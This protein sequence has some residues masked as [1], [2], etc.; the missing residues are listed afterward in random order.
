[1][2]PHEPDG[3][4]WQPPPLSP[5]VAIGYAWAEGEAAMRMVL[6]ILAGIVVA[7]GCV[8]GVEALGHSLYPPPPGLDPTNPRDIDRLMGMLPVM[9]LVFVVAAWFVGALVGALVAN[10]IARQ[11]TAG[12][13]VALLVIA[14]GV[15]TMVMIPHP[16]WM[17]AAGI[18]LPLLAA[19]IAARFRRA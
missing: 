1:M 15:A 7:V 6:G 17:W 9:A 19:L 18:A 14:G 11:G 5:R 8:A 16:A 3:A 2:A 10:Q 4:A 12:W 13:V